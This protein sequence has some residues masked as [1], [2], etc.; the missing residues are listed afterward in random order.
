MVYRFTARRAFDLYFAFE[1]VL[2]RG[3]WQETFGGLFGR[4]V[5]SGSVGK[6]WFAG[7][8]A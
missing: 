8:R 1:I 7:A 2:R 5:N 4:V 3:Y 6:G